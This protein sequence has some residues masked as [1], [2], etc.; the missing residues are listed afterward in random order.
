VIRVALI[1]PTRNGEED[2]ARLLESVGAQTRRCDV[3]V[4]DSSSSDRTIEVAYASGAVVSVIPISEF[5]HG[6]TRQKMVVTKPDYDIYVFLTQD[7]Y[8]ADPD[9]LEHLI[10]PFSDEKV[11]AVCGR[12]L[13]HKD[14]N[15]LAEH[16]RFFNYPPESRIKSMADSPVLGIKTP[17]I[18]NSFAAYRREALL[19]VGGFPSNV[20][21]S[22]DMYVA[23]RMLMAGWKVAYAGDA[24]CHHSHNYTLL[25]E[26]R[27]YFDQGVF[28]SREPWIRESFG[29]AGGEGL[30]YVKSELRY[31]GF[32]RFYLW[33][34]SL[35]RNALKLMGYKLGQHESKLPLWLKRR[36]SMHRGF[37]EAHRRGGIG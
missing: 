17:F 16:A 35:L 36:L 1:I 30:R 23:A 14:A 37:W 12:Q 34:S 24:R 21:L 28:H 9:A 29:G 25:Q 8:L 18:S 4:V 33:P 2:L 13:P 31:L 26:F 15:E 3:F 10:V 5:N 7:A 27:R 11:G 20:I 32:R 6:G 22:E 19:G